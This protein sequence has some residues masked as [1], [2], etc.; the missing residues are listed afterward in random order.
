M[1]GKRITRQQ[2]G[3]YM[4]GRAEGQSQAQAAAKAGVS[5]RSA[6]RVEGGEVSILAGRERHWRTRKDPFAGVWD[7]EIIPLLEGQPGL[8][9]TTL[10]EALQERYPERYDNAKKRTFQRRVTRWKALYGPEREVMFRQVQ[11]PGR[12]GLSDFT[13]L[14]DLVVT[15]GGAPLAHRLYHFRLA[16]SGWSYVSVVL[17]GESYSALAEGLQAALWRLGGAPREHRTDSLSAAYRNL[18]ADDQDGGSNPA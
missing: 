3:L 10:F 6:R 4:K 8:T 14:K 18:P 16:Y 11:E 7:S 15:I 2:V 12:Q 17:G 13:E 5:E 1:S 9:A